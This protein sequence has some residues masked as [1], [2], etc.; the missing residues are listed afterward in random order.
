MVAIDACSLVNLVRY[1]LPF[2]KDSIL[3]NFI[4]NKVES[5]EIIVIDKVYD[6]CDNIAKGIVT[7][8]L[9]FLKENQTNTVE[10]LPDARFFHLLNNDFVNAVNKKKLNAEE[11][12]IQKIAFVENAD[13]KLLLFCK[14]N[15]NLLIKPRIVTEETEGSND[16]K[17][18]KKIPT[19]CKGLDITPLTLPEL[20]KEY[21]DIDINF[22][23]T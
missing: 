10:C 19:L 6:E 2:D 8:T 20:L 7:S 4:K 13:A 5:H 16:N 21:D 18:Y 17:L 22:N 12:E 11:F 23:S 3:F 9:P 14:K 15:E 1:Y